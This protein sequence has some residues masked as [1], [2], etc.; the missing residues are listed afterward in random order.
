MYSIVRSMSLTSVSK[1]NIGQP[2]PLQTELRRESARL[3]VDMVKLHKF[4]RKRR[5]TWPFSGNF[6]KHF[7]GKYNLH[8]QTIQALIKKFFAN[9]ETTTENRKAGNRKARYPYRDKKRFQVVMYKASA[10]RRKGNRIILS[11]GKGVKKLIVRIPSNIPV[12]KI[13]GAELGFRELRLT[14]KQDIETIESAGDNVVAADL[15][16][17]HLA[18]MTDGETS[19][20]IVGRGLRSLIQY[21]NKKLAEFSRLLSKCKK[22]SRRQRKLRTAKAKMLFRNDNQQRNLLHHASKQMVDYCVNQQAGT[23]VVGDCINMSKNARKK[24]KGS[25]RSNQMNSNNPL[26]QLITYLKYK[27]KFQGVKLNKIGEQYTTQS[28]PKCGHK[29]K[30][31]G[32]NYQCKNPE[33]DFIGVRDLVGEANIKNKFENGRIERNY[34]LPPLVAKYRRP[35]K[36][37]VIRPNCVVHLTGGMLLNN[38]LDTVQALSSAD[39]KTSSELFHAA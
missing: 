17:I 28:C 16:V 15:G 12:G 33:C 13:T 30:P 22:G 39:G 21:R 19:E 3:W 2:T 38:T 5:W 20:I 36:V 11:N 18:A 26:G 25:K 4:I 34:L 32:R 7:K 1:F 37:P 6:E 10:I 27:G 9:I 8:S 35:V 31:S 23:L 29:H 14:I 24:K